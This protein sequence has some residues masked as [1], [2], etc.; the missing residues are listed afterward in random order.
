MNFRP[1]EKAKII[2]FNY[3][4]NGYAQNT[5]DS[6]L[7]SSH[8]SQKNHTEKRTTKHQR[9]GFKLTLVAAF[10]LKLKIIAFHSEESRC[11]FHI[12]IKRL[13]SLQKQAQT[14]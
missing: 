4:K 6:K 13:C 3:Y 12:A 8:S 9:I 2:S 14:S 11:L 10:V 7:N 5:T 1:K